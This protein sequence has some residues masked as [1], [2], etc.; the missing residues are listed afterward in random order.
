MNI[1]VWAPSAKS[2]ELVTPERRVPLYP[3]TAERAEAGYWQIEVDDS[4]L[5]HGYRYSIDGGEP[6]P[7]PR[8]KWQ[9]DG[10]H[11]AS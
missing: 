11:G 8:S 2:V 10:V 6:I 4:V 5:A 3:R 9:P 7:D 1:A